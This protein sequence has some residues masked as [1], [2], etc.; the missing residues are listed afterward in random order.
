MALELPGHGDEDLSV[1]ISQLLSSIV[2]DSVRALSD[3]DCDV[4]E[5]DSDGEQL[6]DEAK[7]NVHL[8]RADARKRGVTGSDDSPDVRLSMAQTTDFDAVSPL[9]RCVSSGSL[10]GE[11][12][13]TAGAIEEASGEGDC[14]IS[15]AER[16]TTTRSQSTPPKVYSCLEEVDESGGSAQLQDILALLRSLSVD[17]ARLSP[18]AEAKKAS[19]DKDEECSRR[20]LFKET[21]G[22]Q[23]TSTLAAWQEVTTRLTTKKPVRERR[24]QA[25]ATRRPPAPAAGGRG[26][27]TIGGG[28]EASKKARWLPVGPGGHL[29]GDTEGSQRQVSGLPANGG[30]TTAMQPLTEAAEKDDAPFVSAR[31]QASGGGSW[32]EDGDSSRVGGRIA[33][34]IAG[35]H[36]TEDQW[37]RTTLP[38]KRALFLWGLPP[39][40]PPRIISS[41]RSW[42]SSSKELERIK[43]LRRVAKRQRELVRRCK[44]LPAMG[45]NRIAPVDD[46]A[47]ASTSKS[48]SSQE[49]TPAASGLLP[50]NLQPP[51]NSQERD[52][53]PKED[54][55]E[56]AKQQGEEVTSDGEEAQSISSTQALADLRNILHEVIPDSLG[57]AQTVAAE[58][59][60]RQQTRLVSKS[61]KLRS[62]E[63]KLAQARRVM[64]LPQ[65][66]GAARM[67]RWAA[68]LRS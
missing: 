6:Q 14:M 34:T 21:T 28:E 13:T 4:A 41:G 37:G 39:P 52:R 32:Q 10:A 7:T 42:T 65:R 27:M 45:A 50:G 3:S 60:T 62:S 15:S 54:R 24:G 46:L 19:P 64:E 29:F 33:P 30:C 18:Q 35:G 40:P 55:R 68:Q 8:Q 36:S 11:V 67:Q 16:S 66:F 26:R 51:D 22:G 43:A 56:A 57:K 12:D 5:I 59:A 44:S 63:E 53:S 49:G 47:T 38:L 31:N 2:D 20:Q 48:G 1:D 23:K 61:A 58:A 25:H 17:V 9:R